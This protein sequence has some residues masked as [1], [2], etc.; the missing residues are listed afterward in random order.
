[1]RKFLS[2]LIVAV[3]A[4][5]LTPGVAQAAYTPAGGGTF[6]VPRPWGS[7]TERYRIVRHVETAMKNTQGPTAAFPNPTIHISTYLLDRSQSVDQMVAACRRG[8][9]VRVILD[10]DIVNRN[11]KRLI[12]ILNADNVER[13]ADGTFT[14]PK[15]GPCN[16]RLPGAR[17]A[18]VDDVP[19]T[20]AQA[21]ASAAAPTDAS[22]TWGADGSYVKRCDGSCRGAGGNMHSKFYL[23]SRTGDAQNVVMVSSSNLNRGGALLGWNDLY[24]MNDRPESYRKYVDIHR[25][26]TEDSRAG[27]GKV[28]VQ[29]GPFTSR[30]FP[31]RRASKA[32][33]PT[34]ADLN[35]IGCRSSFGPTQ[36]NVSMF[37]WKGPRGDYL[38][39]KLLNLAR[40][41]CDV[42]IIYGAPSVAIATRLREAAGRNL[43]NLFDSRWDFNNDGYNEIRTHAKYVLVKGDFGGDNAHH[44]VMTGSQNW[45]SGSLSRGDE[46]TL[47]IELQSAWSDYMRN[48]TAI[49]NHARRLPYNR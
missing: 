19:L 37:Y 36:V 1:M 2:V 26:M 15:A 38:A 11:S 30:F 40:S 48:W 9:S 22:A 34:L 32:N 14:R 42:S 20:D 6:N 4:G 43:I 35:K 33:D 13:K 47:N 12:K 29:D 24:T 28:E 25:E 31:M 16:S 27:D 8:V 45:V 39:D 17:S 44:I 10:E 46:T 21:R 41:G 3:L 23:F 49:R 7:D 5:S 18:E